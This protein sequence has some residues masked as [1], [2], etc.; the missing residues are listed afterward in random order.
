MARPRAYPILLEVWGYCS[1]YRTVF[2]KRELRNRGF[3]NDLHWCSQRYECKASCY[4]ADPQFSLQD[5]L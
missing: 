1:G 3:E 2:A 5:W 4:E